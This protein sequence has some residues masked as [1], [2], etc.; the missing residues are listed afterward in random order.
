MQNSARA[1]RM[2]TIFSVLCGSRIYRVG[3]A[4]HHTSPIE[5]SQRRTRDGMKFT[6]RY[7][8]DFYCQKFSTSAGTLIDK[9]TGRTAD[10]LYQ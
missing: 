1:L 10:K 4:L 2:T 7:L 6:T 8:I 5:S 3:A 9:I